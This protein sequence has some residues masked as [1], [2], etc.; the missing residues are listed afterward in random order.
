V[1]LVAREPNDGSASYLIE[2]WVKLSNTNWMNLFTGRNRLYDGSIGLLVRDL[3]GSAL[4]Y[5]EWNDL[6]TLLTGDKVIS[7]VFTMTMTW[8]IRQPQQ[9]Q[10][11]IGVALGNASG[12]HAAADALKVWFEA[13]F[14]D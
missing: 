4:G 8:C 9:L 7:N 14:A 3:L 12:I 2:M 13:L 10:T 1:Q 6:V 5:I 11:H